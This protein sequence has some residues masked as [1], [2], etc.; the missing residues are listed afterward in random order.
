MGDINPGRRAVTAALAGLAAT[1]LARPVRAQSNT[2]AA[3]DGRLGLAIVGP[4]NYARLCMDRIAQCRQV[5]LAGIVTRSPAAVTDLARRHGLGDDAI[6]ALDDL[7]RLA[8]DPRIE[9]VHICLPVGLHAP[10]ARRALAAGKHVLCEKPLAGDPDEAQGLI[11]DAARARRVLMPAYRAWF[12]VA[13]EDL[14]RR[15]REGQHG[16][17]RAVDAHKG[18]VMTLPAGHW[19]FDRTLSGGGCLT[20]I[21]IYSVQL[22]RWLAGGL[23]RRVSAYALHDDPARFGGL[24]TDIHWLAEFDRGVLATGSASWRY[25]LQNRLQLG[26]ELA[27]VEV[28]PATPAMGERMQVALDGPAR[29]ESPMLPLRDQIPTMYDAFADACR[30]RKPQ[31]VPAEEGVADL[32]MMQA[33][34][35][36]AASGRSVAL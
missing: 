33:L 1:T 8:R 20:D 21:G 25:R 32:R 2:P 9:A 27:S 5:R 13:L 15:L 31:P 19:R 22:Q 36:A 3:V 6:H 30:G 24:E 23:P 29:I 7:D 26:F 12:S 28:D 14:Q 11:A 18:F 16:A 17:L 10:Y 34:R 35:E 4:G